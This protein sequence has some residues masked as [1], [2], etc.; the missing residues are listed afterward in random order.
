MGR[1]VRT[2]PPAH[3]K[4]GPH[5]LQSPRGVGSQEMLDNQ[6][7]TQQSGEAESWGLGRPGSVSGPVAGSSEAAGISCQANEGA[8]SVQPSLA[9][10]VSSNWDPALPPLEGGSA[11]R[12]GPSTSE[13]SCPASGPWEGTHPRAP[14]HMSPAS[15]TT[16]SLPFPHFEMPSIVHPEH[17]DLA[18]CGQL[19]RGRHPTRDETSCPGAVTLL[20]YSGLQAAPSVPPTCQSASAQVAASLRLSTISC[21]WRIATEEEHSWCSQLELAAWGTCKGWRKDPQEL[22]GLPCF[23]ELSPEGGTIPHLSEPRTN[24]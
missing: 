23:R 15:P 12:A 7:V 16:S 14:S 17:L 19:V 22:M 11:L 20:E 1:P 4:E 21:R 9:G 10:N 24:T 3:C 8:G 6:G 18:R 2:L 13:T 5:F